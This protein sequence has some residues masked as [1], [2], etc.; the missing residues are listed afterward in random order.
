[1]EPLPVMCVCL[2]CAGTFVCHAHP[3]RCPECQSLDA[4][5]IYFEE[6]TPWVKQGI[7]GNSSTSKENK[8]NYT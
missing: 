3:A 4:G 8:E 1:M 5:W 7:L 2:E 6:R